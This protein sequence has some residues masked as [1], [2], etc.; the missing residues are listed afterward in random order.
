MIKSDTLSVYY[1]TINGTT[2]DTLTANMPISKM[3]AAITHTYSTTIQTELNNTTSSRGT[4]YLQGLSGL[5]AK[6]SFPNLLVNLRSNLAKKDSDIILN[7]A[8]LVLTPQPG[9]FIP[10]RPIPRLTMYRLDI[11]HQRAYVE[12]ATTS[13]DPRSGGPGVFG[14]V[15]N[16]ATNQYIFVITAYMQDLLFNKTTDFGTYIAPVDTSSVTST[17]VPVAATVSVVGRTVAGGGANKSS[18][19]QIRLNIIYTKIAK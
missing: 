9:S 10:Y 5:R 1:R 18:P 3:A 19:Y 7:R 2:I 4:I 12:D 13:A 14:G 16:P 17:A 6:V 11:A 15:Y 8:E